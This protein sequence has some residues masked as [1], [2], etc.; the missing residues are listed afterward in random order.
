MQP[1]DVEGQVGLDLVRPVGLALHGLLPESQGLA[2]L[3]ALAEAD[4][5]GD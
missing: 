4:Q 2:G 1:H 5:P 3:V